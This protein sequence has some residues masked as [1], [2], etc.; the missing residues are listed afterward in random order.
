MSQLLHW[1]NHKP[2]D[3]WEFRIFIYRYLHD[4]IRSNIE[5]IIIRLYDSPRVHF[6][7]IKNIRFDITPLLNISNC[8]YARNVSI[9]IAS[10]VEG[11][12]VQTLNRPAGK[13]TASGNARSY[14]RPESFVPNLQ[15]SE[16]LDVRN[17][18]SPQVISLLSPLYRR[19]WP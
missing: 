3:G 16:F 13:N 17:V 11:L 5:L 6:S 7:L 2:I 10:I 8:I 4:S 14:V 15:I 1:S 9:T 18:T 19:D 12:K